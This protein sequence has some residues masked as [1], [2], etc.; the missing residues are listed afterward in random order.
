M[1]VGGSG[2]I[3]LDDEVVELNRLPTSC[4]S[5]R[6][7]C[8]GFDAGPEGLEIIAVGGSKPEGWRRRPRPGPL[9]RGV[10]RPV[11]SSSGTVLARRI[12]SG[13]S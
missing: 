3:R 5:L 1:V 11:R 10:A 4:G 2:R 12:G 13:E 8:G 7:S 6:T 9:A